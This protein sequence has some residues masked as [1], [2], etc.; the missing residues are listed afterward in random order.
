MKS[1]HAA[2]EKCCFCDQ[3]PPGG[4]N[5]NKSCRTNDIWTARASGEEARDV[6]WNDIDGQAGRG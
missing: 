1:R 3:L 2:G 4:R 6:Q 5:P